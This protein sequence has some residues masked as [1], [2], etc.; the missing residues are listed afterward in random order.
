MSVFFIIEANEGLRFCVKYWK[1]NVIIKRNWYLLLLIKE[2]I[3]KII[4]CKHFIRLNIIAVF[5]KLWMNTNSE[6]LTTFI[7]VFGVYKYRVLLFG[8]TNSPIIFQLYINDIFWDF[9]NEFCQA[10]SDNNFIYSKTRK[11]HWQ[12][13][14]VVLGQ[15]CKARLQADI[16]KWKFDL[17][18]TSFLGVIILS[19]RFRID[20]SKVKAIV[21]WLTHTNLKQI[22][23]FVAF[24]NSYQQFIKA[25]SKLVKSLV[26]LIMK[27]ILFV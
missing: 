24:A 22:E 27:D 3:G 12:N 9:F 1:L 4:V 8:P 20:L 11:K 17:Q 10:Y 25:F 5:N 19:N 6:D 16:K 23:K 18:E 13:N 2:A 15:S 7:M 14:L 26:I 21:K